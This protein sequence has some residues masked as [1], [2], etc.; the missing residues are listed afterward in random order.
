M[1]N[2]GGALHLGEGSTASL[3]SCTLTGN[4]ARV[5]GALHLDRSTA[6]LTSCL[7]TGNT[8][9]VRLHGKIRVTW[10][11]GRSADDDV[12]GGSEGYM[13]GEQ[14]LRRA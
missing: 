9:G 8:A 3:T 7:L 14:G 5:G 12:H 10:M 13:G 4:I 1:Q 11:H 6:S 2:K